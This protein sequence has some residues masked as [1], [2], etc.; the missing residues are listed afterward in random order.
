[1]AEIIWTVPALADLDAIAD[2]VALDNPAAAT[3]LVRRVF[4]HVEQLKDH[5]KSGS[6]PKELKPSRTYRQIVEPPC[7]VFYRIE[8]ETIFVVYVMRGERL[9]RRKN[10]PRESE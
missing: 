7:R 8:G 9:F 1:M 2:Y 3:E 4:K 10:L 6:L 5:P